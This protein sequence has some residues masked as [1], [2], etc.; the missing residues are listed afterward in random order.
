[1]PQLF[2]DCYGSKCHFEDKNW[3]SFGGN[4]HGDAAVKALDA[5]CEKVTDDA[6][7]M[8]MYMQVIFNDL[9]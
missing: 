9:E 5:F 2:R 8:T 3:K 6:N 1:M 7:S 4:S